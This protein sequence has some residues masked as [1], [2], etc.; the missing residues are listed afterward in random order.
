MQ[1]NISPLGL[2]RRV[3]F[4]SEKEINLN[5]KSSIKPRPRRLNSTNR[6]ID[7]R[8]TFSGRNAIYTAGIS[9]LMNS[10][11]ARN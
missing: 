11:S 4:S 1:D 5:G 6:S 3:T 8:I 7:E 10:S 9:S 2:K